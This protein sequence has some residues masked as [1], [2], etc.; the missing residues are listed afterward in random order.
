M[1]CRRR[2]RRRVRARAE[3]D[4]C[5]QVAGRASAIAD[6]PGRGDP[7]PVADYVLSPFEAETDVGALVERAAD[8]VEAIARDGL[9]AAQQRFN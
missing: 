8:A 1:P 2:Q 5:A 9:E 7:R 4:W 3:L 6:R